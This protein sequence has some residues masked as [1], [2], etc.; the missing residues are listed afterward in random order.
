MNT[1]LLLS[2]TFRKWGW[3]IFAPSFILGVL[4]LFLNVEF[5]WLGKKVFTIYAGSEIGRAHV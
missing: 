2:H 4:V 3:I 1:N 5:D